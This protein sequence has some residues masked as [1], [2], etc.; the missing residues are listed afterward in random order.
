[1]IHL[2]LITFHCFPISQGAPARIHRNL[3]R[4][5]DECPF[6]EETMTDIENDFSKELKS[7]Q[8][9]GVGDQPHSGTTFLHHLMSTAA[10]LRF[11]KRPRAEQLAGLFHAI[12]A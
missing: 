11:H 5:R 4:P 9:M 7:L 12:Y 3:R 10:F 8:T 2:L 1:M 6:W